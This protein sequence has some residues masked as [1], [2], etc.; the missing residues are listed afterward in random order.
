MEDMTRIGDAGELRFP[1]RDGPWS[2]SCHTFINPNVRSGFDPVIYVALRFGTDRVSIQKVFPAIE[3]HGW[4]VN[5]AA[6]EFVTYLRD[7]GLEVCVD[8]DRLMSMIMKA[9]A[10]VVALSLSVIAKHYCEAVGSDVVANV[11]RAEEVRRVL[12]G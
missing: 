3:I 1:D 11:W 10:T 2:I 8:P 6:R 4:A 7:R 12:E 9:R 5:A